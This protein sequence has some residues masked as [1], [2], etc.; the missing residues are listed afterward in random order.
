MC[1]WES[2]PVVIQDK[3]KWNVQMVVV[4]FFWKFLAMPIAA[5]IFGISALLENLW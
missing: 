2:W 3:I 1:C 5:E 4:R